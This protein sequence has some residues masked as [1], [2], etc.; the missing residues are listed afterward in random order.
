MIQHPPLTSRNRPLQPLAHGRY[1]GPHDG[2]IMK[3]GDRSVQLIKAP[4]TCLPHVVL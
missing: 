2:G 1:L 3:A 4:L